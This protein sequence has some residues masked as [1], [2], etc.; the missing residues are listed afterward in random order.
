MATLN[1]VRQPDE[2]QYGDDFDLFFDRMGAYLTNVKAEAANQYSLF[3]SYLDPISFRKAQAI[4][5]TIMI[6]I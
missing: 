3:L 2:F 5:F 6:I 4:V 1:I